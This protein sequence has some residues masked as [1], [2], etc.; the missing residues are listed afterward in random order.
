SWARHVYWMFNIVLE[1]EAWHNR[2]VVIEMLSK[3]GIET[4]PV[5]Y[6]VHSLPPYADCAGGDEAFPVA[7][8]LSRNGI[9]LPTW[10]GLTENDI[11]KVCCALEK[12]RKDV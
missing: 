2:D 9:S 5:F 3:Q 12:C 10:A 6:P 7:G 11:D 4:R 8:N 1:P